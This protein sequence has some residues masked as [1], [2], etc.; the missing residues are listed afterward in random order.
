MKA[1]KPTAPRWAVPSM[2]RIRPGTRPPHRPKSV[3]DDA[4]SAAR[5]R[6]KSAAAIVHGA[7][8]SGMSK[9]SAPPPAASA[10]L[11]VAAPS[12]SV[13]PGSLKCT[14]TSMTAGSATSPV[15]LIVVRPSSSGPMSTMVPPSIAMSACCVPSVVT[16]MLLRMTRST[17]REILEERASDGERRGD[18]RDEHRLVGMMADATRASQEE[19]R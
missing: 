14:W 2:S 5:L 15:A 8:L 12:H 19:H 4:S 9:N 10:R 7:E 16:M 1:L 11:P 18:I 3:I 17:T 13:R 6:S